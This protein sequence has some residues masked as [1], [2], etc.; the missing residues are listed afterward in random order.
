MSQTASLK[1]ELQ[2]QI[3]GQSTGRDSKFRNKR[4]NKRFKHYLR[5]KDIPNESK[6]FK[7]V[8][9]MG[10]TGRKVTSMPINLDKSESSE[11]LLKNSLEILLKE[12]NENLE[13]IYDIQ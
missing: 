6:E 1:P 5:N 8:T 12:S 10:I 7:Q 13:Q 3:T 9:E 4:Q 2:I 11:R